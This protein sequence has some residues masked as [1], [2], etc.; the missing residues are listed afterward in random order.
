MR[1]AT[2][3][4][5]LAGACGGTTVARTSLVPMGHSDE[6]EVFRFE[7]NFINTYVIQ[8]PSGM[9]LV[10]SGFEA[11]AEHLVTALRTQGLEPADLKLIVV[12]HGHADH[13]GGARVLREAFG[14][15]VWVG[16]DDAAFLAAG[17]NQ[18]PQDP[19]LCPRGPLARLRLPR[20]ERARYTPFQP[21]HLITSTEDLT[22]VLGVPTQVELLP[23]HTAGSLVVYS[24]P[25]AFV[26][27][28]FR[29]G[30]FDASRAEVHL[31][32]CDLEDN[33]RDI[34][35]LL[36]KHPS[37]AVHFPGHFGPISRNRL[38]TFVRQWSGT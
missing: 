20:S 15:P 34:E 27:D 2:V 23:G 8:G 38:E 25:F 31:Y 10:D 24:G 17:Q 21:D 6:V 14:T 1:R 18:T 5:S 29:G 33:R 4:L 28:L 36:N 12:T 35:N 16:A 19:H 7:R 32:M 37:V 26:G 13:A 9:I 11:D 30:F 3:L 22:Q